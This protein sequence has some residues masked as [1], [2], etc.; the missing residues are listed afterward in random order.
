MAIT[1]RRKR[2]ASPPRNVHELRRQRLVQFS[3]N[4]PQENHTT[5]IAWVSAMALLAFIVAAVS[6]HDSAETL[7]GGS[8][9]TTV[10]PQFPNAVLKWL[11]V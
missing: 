10:S 7:F 5:C 3:P 1:T 2:Y 6:M 4:S 11:G 8:G 9:T